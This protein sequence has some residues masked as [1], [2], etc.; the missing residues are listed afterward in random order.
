[1]GQAML[2]YQQE[3]LQQQQIEAANQL[4]M[5]SSEQLEELQRQRQALLTPEQLL[6]QQE[7]VRMQSLELPPTQPLPVQLEEQIQ[8]AEMAAGA[9]WAAQSDS[10]SAPKASPAPPK[11]AG[12]RMR[13]VLGGLVDSANPAE[14]KTRLCRKFEMGGCSSGGICNFA[15]GRGELRKSESDDPPPTN[16]PALRIKMGGGVACGR[17]VDEKKTAATKAASDAATAAAREAASSADPWDDDTAAKTWVD[18]GCGSFWP[19]PKPVAPASAELPV[20]RSFDFGGNSSG[21]KP[22]T[23]GPVPSPSKNK[24]PTDRLAASLGLP[25]KSTKAKL[26]TERLASSLGLNPGPAKL[27]QLPTERL[28]ASLGLAMGIKSKQPTERLADYF[29]D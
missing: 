11:P 3:Q 2:A 22:L 21:Q 5:L 17:L 19:V 13:I 18:D 16:K 1:M 4:A 24:L 23:A 28:A 29:C 8:A 12:G 9:A 14:F 25:S 6:E 20:S 27:K 15:H 10:P 7:L 26:P